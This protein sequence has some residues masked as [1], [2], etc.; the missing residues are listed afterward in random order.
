MLGKDQILI[1]R[2]LESCIKEEISQVIDSS[3]KIVVITD[4][5]V[6][7]L[8]SSIVTIFKDYSP[9]VLT[10]RPG[11]VSKSNEIKQVGNLMILEFGN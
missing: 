8:Y 10:V 5:N 2:D 7:S 4:N 3:C 9:L 11:E 6:I 1:G